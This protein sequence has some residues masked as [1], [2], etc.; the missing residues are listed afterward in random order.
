[1]TVLRELLGDLDVATLVGCVGIPYHWGHGE[2]DS[3]FPD[4]SYDCSGFAQGALVHLR[5][6]G[7]SQPDRTAHSLSH[8]CDPI[9]EGGQVKGDL[10]FY[11]K[12]GA[13]THVMVSIGNEW[14]VGASGGDSRTKGGN[15]R[16]HVRL[17]RY[18][19]RRDFLCFGRVKPE[20]RS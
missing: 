7:R 2:P 11:G 16:A 17:V 10:A 3:L 4:D 8:I 1:V 18:D 20:Y 6:L 9:E 14:T 5:L 19:Y 15:P 12:G 13:V